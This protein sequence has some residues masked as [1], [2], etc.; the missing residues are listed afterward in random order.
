MIVRYLIAILA[1]GVTSSWT[2][3]V[4]AREK[5]G[6]TIVSGKTVDLFDD[7]TWAYE[8]TIVPGSDCQAIT[9]GLSFCGT[10]SSWEPVQPSPGVLAEY[11][12]DD[13]NYGEV[14]S[15][16]LGSAQGMTLDKL[17]SIAIGNV[18]TYANIPVDQI[19]ILKELQQMSYN[20]MGDTLVYKL[21]VKGVPLV[22]ADTMF[23]LPDKEVQ[24]LTL[25]VGESYGGAEQGIHN[26]F[27]SSVKI[28]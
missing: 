11:R 21:L 16:K 17:K 3:S 24:V 18:A 7:N 15:E 27:L 9:D 2:T 5:V 20:R 19:A 28:D 8:G 6:T 26:E 14:G 22:I 12:Y 25:S 4:E 13:F 1:I 10:S 23:V